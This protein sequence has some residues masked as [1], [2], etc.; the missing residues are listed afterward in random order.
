M[1]E[2]SQNSYPLLREFR[3]F[4]AEIARLRRMVEEA[5]IAGASNA[6][7]TVAGGAAIGVATAEANGSGTGVISVAVETADTVTSRVWYEMT[8]YLDQKMY[9]VKA[10]ASSVSHDIL[11]QLVYIM[12]AF[13]D[14]TFVCLLEWN[15][16]DYWRDNLMELRLFHSQIAGRDIFRRIDRVLAR[17]DY[18]TE[19]LAA[20]YLMILALGFKGQY[21]RD[22]EAIEVYRRKLFDRLLL[23]NPDLKWNGRRIF[24]EAYRHTVSEGAPVKLPEPRKWWGVVAGIVAAWLIVSTIVWLVLVNPTR[25]NLAITQQA[26]DAVTNQGST[27]D[28]SS[29]WK[30]LA[31]TLQGGAFHLDL[32]PSLPVK[33]AAAGEMGPGVA[34]L[35]IAV[36]G[37]GGQGA[38]S[39]IDAWLSSGLSSFPRNIANAAPQTRSVASV[40]QIPPPDGVTTSAATLF[41]L[42]DPGLSAQ[43]LALHPTLT[44]PVNTKSGATDV[45]LYLSDRASAVT[46]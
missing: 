40:E 28:T 27:E 29:K 19:E 4:Y 22:P 2:R 3:E 23:T 30:S 26:L 39:R 31:F 5:R 36:D 43:D 11:E 7:S 25:K 32:P 41:F 38:A 44:F 20:V 6:G 1:L 15:G 46:P 17:Q 42:V 16:K 13:A 10:A 14:E 35:L 24:P 37:P 34:P 45:T 18:G 12:A 8:R 21:L 9:E 33:R